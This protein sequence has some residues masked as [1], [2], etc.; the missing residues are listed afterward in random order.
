[1][2][3]S[4]TVDFSE[5]AK[6]E[7]QGYGFQS[8]IKQIGTALGYAVSAG[9][10]GSDEGKDLV[11][12]ITDKTLYGKKAQRRWLVSCKDNSKG[13]AKKSVLAKDLNSSGSIKDR[14][15]QHKCDGFLLACTTRPTNDVVSMLEKLETS[16]FLTHYWDGDT[17]QQILQEN[18]EALLYTLIRFFPESYAS[19]M[20][21]LSRLVE[22][23]IELI[24]EGE[25]EFDDMQD[26]VGRVQDICNSTDSLEVK[27]RLGEA[28]LWRMQKTGDDAEILYPL[29]D[30]WIK[31]INVSTEAFLHALDCYLKDICL[32]N[33]N[34]K[35][36]CVLDTKSGVKLFQE[37]DKYILKVPLITAKAN[38]CLCITID[39]EGVFGRIQSWSRKGS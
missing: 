35:T 19:T 7:K 28:V 9:G 16:A 12:S 17:I 6:R 30:E 34:L 31:F 36:T 1:M 11:F 3:R 25:V 18:E 29:L 39:D 27:Q 23:L 38:T 2:R 4:F 13:K 15:Q 10:T 33:L 5:L 24:E 32:P 8:L 22:N 37:E 14:T 26:L 20:P 21:L